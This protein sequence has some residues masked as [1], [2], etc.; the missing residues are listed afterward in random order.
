MG[1]LENKC[2][3]NYPHLNPRIKKVS[4]NKPALIAARST[5][6]RILCVMAKFEAAKE[7][8]KPG[9]RY[10]DSGCSNELIFIYSEKVPDSVGI[11]S[12]YY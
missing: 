5:E 11:T 1:H 9:N 4:D 3:V 7:P 2:W 6:D 10:I 8:K 12:T